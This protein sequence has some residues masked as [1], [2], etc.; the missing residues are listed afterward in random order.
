MA[1]CCWT[2]EGSIQSHRVVLC[3]ESGVTLGSTESIFGVTRSGACE[4]HAYVSNLCS[5]GIPRK[6]S[7]N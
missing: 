5:T 6:E 7:I 3:V 2:C 4:R 1:A